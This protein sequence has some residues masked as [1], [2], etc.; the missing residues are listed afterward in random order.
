MGHSTSSSL[1]GLCECDLQDLR[2]YLFCVVWGLVFLL[3]VDYVPAVLI[4]VTLRVGLPVVILGFPG[5]AFWVLLNIF[6]QSL[7]VTRWLKSYILRRLAGLALWGQTFSSILAMWPLALLWLSTL[8]SRESEGFWSLCPAPATSY[9]GISL[10]LS[11]GHFPIQKIWSSSFFLADDKTC[12]YG[13]WFS[14]FK[15]YMG[16]RS[17]CGATWV[18]KCSMSEVFLDVCHSALC[19]SP[20]LGHPVCSALRVLV[21]GLVPGSPAP[22]ELCQLLRGWWHSG[23]CGSLVISQ[24]SLC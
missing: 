14:S 4:T 5:L 22:N 1:Q 16:A 19:F 18:S 23:A 2:V 17:I 6:Q 12:K 21:P 9:P 7:G 10:L 11:L 24:D 3:V 20:L 13:A 8:W 15:S